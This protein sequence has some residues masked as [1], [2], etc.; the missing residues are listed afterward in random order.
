[1]LT[2]SDDLERTALHPESC[3]PGYE[4]LSSIGSGGFGVVFKARQLALD[5]VVAIKLLRFDKPMTP[6]LDGRF[7]SEARI[8]GLLHHPN[9][10]QIHD[11][12]HHNGRVFLAMELLEGEDLGQRLADGRPLSEHAAWALAGQIAAALGHAAEHGVIHRDIKPANLFLTVPPTGIGWPRDVPFV[13]VMDFGLARI[14]R[15]FGAD[16]VRLTQTNATPGTPLYMAPE[17]HRNAATLDHRADIYALGATVFHVLSG[18]P[19][20]PGPTPWD[21]VAQKIE[22][23]ISFDAHLAPESVALLSAMLAP[24]PKARI[25]NYEELIARIEQL[26]AMRAHEPVSSTHRDRPPA[27]TS[28]TVRSRFPGTRWRWLAVASVLTAAGVGANWWIT[29]QPA[30]RAQAALAEYD[31]S[32][33]HESLFESRS[34]ASWVPPS[35]GGTWHTQRDDE[36]LRVLEG[37]GYAR[38]YFSPVEDYRIALG[39]DLHQAPAAEVHFAIPSN[40]PEK[41]QRLV[42]RVTKSDGAIFGTRDGDKGAFRP[43][44]V[45]VPFPPAS[46]FETRRP[47]LEVRFERAGGRWTAWFHGTEVGQAIDDGIAKSPEFRLVAEGGKTIRV[48]SAILTP[49]KRR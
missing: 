48:D 26:P 15:A 29:R 10:V 41:G 45:A 42:L 28:R 4:L 13:K 22:H 33:T 6:E 32:G 30:I 11:Y 24:D 38:R 49:L 40:A 35:A 14:N 23:K 9:I 44:G 2:P 25:G 37:T 46:W 12:G 21:L 3:L 34:I 36:N 8:L 43:V 19:P 20:F 18:R 1:M 7:E 5:R 17:Q 27:S 16:D 47:Y 39:L 31:S